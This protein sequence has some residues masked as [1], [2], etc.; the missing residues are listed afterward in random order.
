[1]H[2]LL[3]RQRRGHQPREAG[4][5]RNEITGR[6]FSPGAS[7]RSQLCLH[8]DFKLVSFIADSDFQNCKIAR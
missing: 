1:M 3:W 4:P 6:R 8:F 2:C 7:G 5:S